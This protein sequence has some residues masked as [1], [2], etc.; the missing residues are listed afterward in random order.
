MAFTRKNPE[1]P[2]VAPAYVPAVR[3]ALSLQPVAQWLWVCAGLVFAMAIIGAITRLTE[4]GLSI[5]EWNPIGGALPPLS[6]AEWQ[7]LFAEYQQTPQYQK[8]NHGMTLAEFKGIFWWEWIHRFWGRLIGVVFAVPLLWFAV[9]RR[10]KGTLLLQLLGL[11]LLGGLQGGIGWFMVASGLVDQPNVSHYRLAL[12]LGFAIFLMALLVYMALAVGDTRPQGRQP[13]AGTA[14][15]GQLR[16]TFSLLAITIVWGAFVAGLDAGLIYNEF[17]YMGTTLFPSEG[18]DI[19]PLWRNFIENH[20]AVQ[21]THRWLAIGTAFFVLLLGFEILRNPNVSDRA[22]QLGW[23]VMGMVCVQVALGI[24][25]L[26]T[27]VQIHPAVSHQG[28][29][30]ILVG[31]MTALTYELRGR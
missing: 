15:M 22:R 30:L 20:A 28:G 29:A 31:L 25:T 8:I 19:R 1:A 3:P 24:V 13:R 7:R 27:N 23:A 14:L 16:F 26:L 2:L 12:H 11:L 17:P 5:V 6:A 18:L 4:S 10:V 21:F 9:T